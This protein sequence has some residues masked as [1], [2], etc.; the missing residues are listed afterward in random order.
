[1]CCC[2]GSEF[3]HSWQIRPRP[4][5]SGELFSSAPLHR[6]V[7]G[8]G[9]WKRGYV[10]LVAGQIDAFVAALG[11]GSR[12]EIADL[13]IVYVEFFG[14]FS[15]QRLLRSFA[16]FYFSA[17]KFPLATFGLVWVAP[18]TRILPWCSITAPTTRMT[19]TMFL[20]YVNGQRMSFLIRIALSELTTRRLAA[21]SIET[22]NL[23]RERGHPM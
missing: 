14:Y 21:G 16:R 3:F 22:K 4:I 10:D 2:A 13:C 18:A 9:A 15:G 8:A 1:M 19:F 12:D 11:G 17:G 5:E 7:I 23:P 20:G 6:V